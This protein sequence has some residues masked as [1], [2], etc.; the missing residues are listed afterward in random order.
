MVIHGAWCRSI[1]FLLYLVVGFDYICPIIARPLIEP[2][3]P[4]G[5]DRST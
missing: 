5:K 3:F 2:S 4:I 1:F